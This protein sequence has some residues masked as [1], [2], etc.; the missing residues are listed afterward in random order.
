VREEEEEEVL[1]LPTE[2][3]ELVS[4]E[5]TLGRDRSLIA[6]DGGAC[7]G[8]A[9]GRWVAEYVLDRTL[10]LAPGPEKGR[11]G[12]EGRTGAGMRGCWGC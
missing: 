9:T 2:T 1:M 5:V 8:A 11:G 6:G 4:I 7:R 12:S 3:D 10:G